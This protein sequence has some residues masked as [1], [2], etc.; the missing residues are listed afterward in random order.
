M[1]D[2]V[3]VMYAGRVARRQRP[4]K[5]FEHPTH[6][7]TEG[8]LAAVP[9]IDAPRVRL[10]AFPARSRRDAWPSGCRFRRAA[11]TPGTNVS[12]SRRLLGPALPDIPRAAGS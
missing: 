5:L 12:L 10:H 4:K 8:L 1:P 6:P 2:R 3:V 11:P 7:Y 9:R